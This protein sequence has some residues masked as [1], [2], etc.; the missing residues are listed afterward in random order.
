VLQQV[1][2]QWAAA[3]I[4]TT[5]KIAD[6]RATVL[7]AVFGQY[8]AIFFSYFAT[9]D[10]DENYYFWSGKNAAPAGAF[11][12]NFSRLADPQLDAAL[13]LAHG[14]VDIDTR[15]QAYKTVQERFAD[16]V[17]YVWLYQLDWII[18]THANVKQARFVTTPDGQPAIPYIDGVFSLTETY[19]ATQ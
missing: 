12:V 2:D 1:S 5:V 16:Q 19:I 17:P 13:D 8:D 4:K 9:V 18:A 3:G 10:P 15:K 6:A 7:N 11:S 14:T